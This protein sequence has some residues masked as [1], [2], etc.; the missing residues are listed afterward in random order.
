MAEQN[1]ITKADILEL[2]PISQNI[3][4]ERVNPF[5]RLGQQND[6]TQWLGEPL[7]FAFVEDF[8]GGGD[9]SEERF[10]ELFDGAELELSNSRTVY[11]R[12]VKPMLVAFAYA[13]LVSNNSFHVTRGG[14]V[15]KTTDQSEAATDALELQ[16]ARNAMSEAYRLGANLVTFL[17]RKRSIYPEWTDPA[18]K[19]LSFNINRVPTRQ[20][21]RVL[22]RG[23]SR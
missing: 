1:I 22:P 21:F 7:Y 17:D 16:K 9:F 2:W 12:G 15:K 3:N 19:N 5:I 4:D 20:F 8:E 10:Q 13:R 14:D 6:L 18:R 11:F 23:Q